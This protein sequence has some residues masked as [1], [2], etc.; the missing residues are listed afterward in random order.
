MVFHT[1]SPADGDAIPLGR[2]ID[3]C[4]AVIIDERA[5]P[6]PPGAVGEIVIGGVCLGSGYFGDPAAHR[7][8]LFMP[9]PFPEIP[10]ARLYRTGDLGLLRRARPALFPG[11]KDF[12]VKIGGVRIELGELEVVAEKCPHVRARR[13][14]SSPTSASAT[15]RSAVFASGDETDRGARCV[16]HLRRALPRSSVPRYYF[17]APGHAAERQRQGRPATRCRPLLDGTARRAT[18]SRSRA[19]G[20]AGAR[21][22]PG[23]ARLSR[24]AR[25]PGAGRRAPTSSTPAATRSARWRRCSSLTAAFGVASG[26]RTCST[27]RRALGA[28]PADRGK[29]RPRI[30]PRLEDEAALMARDAVAAAALAIGAAAG[31]ARC[32]TVLRRPA[33]PA[34][35][36]AASSTSC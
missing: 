4:Y 22:R 11:R 32:E 10:G 2:P 8:R 14:S 16:E 20:A 12:Q 9:N 7:R 21:A 31:A 25:A 27:T 23:A 35:S 34:S 33:R 15:S 18:P 36:A 29:R 19:R 3:N 24:R 13:R 26:A 6:L 17:A 30:R 1:V 5:P 28:V